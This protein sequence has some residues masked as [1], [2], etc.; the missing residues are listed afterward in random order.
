[1]A[2]EDDTTCFYQ[3]KKPRNFKN[4]SDETLKRR[5]DACSIKIRAAVSAN[6][7]IFSSM[8]K[9]SYIACFN[10]CMLHVRICVGT[11]YNFITDA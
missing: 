11:G 2:Q 6:Q 4:I 9:V 5:I 8:P 7:H 1:M 10:H 3:L